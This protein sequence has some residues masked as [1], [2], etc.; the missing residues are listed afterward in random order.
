LQAVSEVSQAAMAIRA[1]VDAQQQAG[2]AIAT[3]ARDTA[4]A[5]THVLADLSDIRDAA[6]DTENLSRKVAEASTSLRGISTD[7]QSATREFV[8]K[9]KAA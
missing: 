2:T 6:E 1:A 8:N 7:L 4:S 9:L 3:S 5:A